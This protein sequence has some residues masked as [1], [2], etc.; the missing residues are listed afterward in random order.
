[1]MASMNNPKDRF[2][3]TAFWEANPDEE[4]A[5]HRSCRALA[6]KRAKRRAWRAS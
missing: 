3:V 5:V 1:M 4:E 2:V 6:R